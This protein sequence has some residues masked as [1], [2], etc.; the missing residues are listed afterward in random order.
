MIRCVPSAEDS[1]LSVRV[2]NEYLEY[3]SEVGA[4]GENAYYVIMSEK[5]TMSRSYVPLLVFISSTE[6]KSYSKK[7][8]PDTR[9]L[10]GAVA[11]AEE[12]AFVYCNRDGIEMNIF[13]YSVGSNYSITPTH[14]FTTPMTCAGSGM[15]AAF[16]SPKVNEYT[17]VWGDL[18]NDEYFF[19][20]T[21]QKLADTPMHT[22]TTVK[23]VQCEDVHS[24][25]R[26]RAVELLYPGADGSVYNCQARGVG[27]DAPD[28]LS[29]ILYQAGLVSK[30]NAN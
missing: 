4:Y 30:E 3:V 28:R 16:S 17:L 11:N 14:T 7:K 23:R 21:V 6:A 24:C 8:L 22:C 15:S 10:L 20:F 26:Y 27:R 18:F 19:S 12:N 5:W 29:V 13:I 1:R 9:Y 2:P 25:L